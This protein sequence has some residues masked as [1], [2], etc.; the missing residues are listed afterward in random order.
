MDV[1]DGF[2]NTEIIEKIN[3]SSNDAKEED[4]NIVDS[5]LNEEGYK[6]EMDFPQFKKEKS[7]VE[8]KKENI[9]EKKILIPRDYQLKIYNV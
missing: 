5:I 2:Q 7:M 8:E 9:I 1:N 4:E 3:N 6:E